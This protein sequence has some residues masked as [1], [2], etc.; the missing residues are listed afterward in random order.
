MVGSLVQPVM[1]HPDAETAAQVAPSLVHSTLKFALA[2]VCRPRKVEVRSVSQCHVVQPG[3]WCKDDTR[4]GQKGKIDTS[5]GTCTERIG[6]I[7]KVVSGF[8]LF[9]LP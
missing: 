4:T 1:R 3:T 7:T 5:R 6:S 8:I 9:T 2:K